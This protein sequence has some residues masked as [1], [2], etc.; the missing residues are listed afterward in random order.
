M[1]ELNAG[2][3]VYLRAVIKDGTVD[4]EGEMYACIAVD[5]SRNG[6]NVDY[7]RSTYVPAHLVG[8]EHVVTEAAMSARVKEQR[9]STPVDIESFLEA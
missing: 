1:S 7:R 4:A 2:D 8:T 3:V 5:D 9:F 6:T